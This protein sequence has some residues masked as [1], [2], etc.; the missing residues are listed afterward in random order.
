MAE[1]LAKNVVN[2]TR[3]ANSHV[4]KKAKRPAKTLRNL[5]EMAGT[6]ARAERRVRCVWGMM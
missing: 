6:R 2:A 3:L 5:D 1:R 4:A